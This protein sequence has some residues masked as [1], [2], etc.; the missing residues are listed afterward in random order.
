M[1]ERQQQQIEA[2]DID[3]INRQL[4]SL[5]RIGRLLRQNIRLMDVLGQVAQ[6]VI[7]VTDSDA[8]SI[9]LMQSAGMDNS[10]RISQGSVSPEAGI[11][12]IEKEAASSHEAIARQFEQ[13]PGVVTSLLCYPISS[14]EVPIGTITII[15]YQPNGLKPISPSFIGAVISFIVAAIDKMGIVN[16]LDQRSRLIGRRYQQFERVAEVGNQIDSR[17]PKDELYSSLTRIIGQAVEFRT[18]ILDLI[19]DEDPD[20]NL[21]TVAAWGLSDFDLEA[22]LHKKTQWQIFEQLLRPEFALGATYFL[23]IE[24]D[25]SADSQIDIEID[26]AKQSIERL[27]LSANS[28]REGDRYFAPLYRPHGQPVGL[29]TLGDP[30]SGSRPDIDTALLA[31]VLAKYAVMIVEESR[32]VAEVESRDREVSTL[33][34]VS[35]KIQGA[36]GKERILRETADYLLQ[37]VD[38]I[39]CTIYEWSRESEEVSVNVVATKLPDTAA[40]SEGTT[41]ELAK[42]VPIRQVLESQSPL[43]LNL[44]DSDVHPPERFS[45]TAE[46]G[47]FTLALLPIELGG[48]IF[49]AAELL[50]PRSGRDLGAKEIKLLTAVINQAAVALENAQLFDDTL[51]RERFF[52]ALGRVTLAMN[53][54]VDLS[55]VL[56]LICRESLSLFGVDGAYIWQKQGDRLIGVAARGFQEE[57]FVDSVASIVDEKVFASAIASRGRGEFCNYYQSQTTYTKHFPPSRSIVSALGVPLRM[58]EDINGVLVM[59]DTEKEDRFGPEDIERATLFGTQAAIAI[60]NAQL[61]TDLRDLNEQLDLRVSERTQALG[62][63]RDRVRYLLRVTTELSETLDEDRVVTRA[64]ELVSEVVDAHQGVILLIDPM[65]GRLVY[66]SAYKTYDLQPL[67]GK[68]PEDNTQDGISGWVIENRSSTIINNLSED[69]R[70]NELLIGVELSSA[71]AVPLIAGDDVIGV[72]MLFHEKSS[73][74]SKEQLEL[75][76][77]AARQ[78]GS[79]ISNAQL[80]LLIRDQ[81]EKLGQML[82]EESVESAKNQAILESIAD[83]V[84]V[85]DAGGYIILANFAACEILRIPH[86]TL[87]GKPATDLLGLYASFGERWT[88]T[89]QEWASGPRSRY[90]RSFLSHTLRVEDRYVS[91]HLS[92]VFANDQFSGTVSIFRDVTHSVEV[93]RMKSEFVSTVSH[94]LRTPMTSIRGYADLMLMGVAGEMT[95]QQR[96]YLSVIKGNASRMTNLVI[97]L[98]DIAR[99]ESGK[100]VLNLREVDVTDLITVAT[101]DHL[102]GLI[103]SGDKVIDARVDVE[104]SLPLVLADSERVVQILTNL[105]DNAYNYSP[106]GGVITINARANADSVEVTVG[107]TGIGIKEEYQSKIFERFYR[108]DDDEVQ[109]VAGTGL[110]LSIVRSLVLLHG[111]TIEVDSKP[112]EGS[113]F[114]FSLPRARSDESEK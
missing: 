66:P 9:H 15:S 49:G 13:E 112:A 16:E 106:S 34:E 75:V 1:R 14:Q 63:E 76:E 19:D 6:E 3:L 40:L 97:D 100:T 11:S 81:A 23:P 87:I 109:R 48:E 43:L 73:A 62:Q 84:V 32:L 17:G 44:G 54:T 96:Q 91:A 93:D 103:E 107:D 41:H 108:A 65:T 53:Q 74:F 50:I 110:G 12:D 10:I 92:P 90:Q 37:M 68:L 2:P 94:E 57:Q 67:P 99:I 18:V 80:F 45:R 79:A 111:G 52:A 29:L 7:D 47:S 8:A 5:N 30:V 72:L 4:D 98:L 28:W 36:L 83:G 86:D 101:N 56:T 25:P 33:F 64:L 21:W 70:A 71:L 27:T 105:I 22:L 26:S 35:Q 89:H 104:P 114:I 51:Q 82:R 24:N 39:D 95:D 60:R 69:S 85:A 102:Q 78:V 77:A 46:S 20:L 61:V 55:A 88:A 31:E 59:V 58:D 42:L 113:N 38:A